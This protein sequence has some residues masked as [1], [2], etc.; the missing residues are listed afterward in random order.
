[1]KDFSI[2]SDDEKYTHVKEVLPKVLSKR[3]ILVELVET[4]DFLL[5]LGTDAETIKAQDEYKR[6]LKKLNHKIKILQD[7]CQEYER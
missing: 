2:M 6:E 1:M 4:G 7:F 5:S 3:G